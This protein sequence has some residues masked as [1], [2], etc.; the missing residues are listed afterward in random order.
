MRSAISRSGWQ[1]YR[2]GTRASSGT[3]K[4]GHNQSAVVPNVSVQCR[5]PARKK[6]AVDASFNSSVFTVPMIVFTTETVPPAPTPSRSEYAIAGCCWRPRC[7]AELTRLIWAAHESPQNAVIDLDL[8][9][10]QCAR[11]T[12][13]AFRVNQALLMPNDNPERACSAAG[14]LS[15]TPRRSKSES[16]LRRS[17]AHSMLLR[18]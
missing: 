2:R 8:I 11:S 4:S 12:T 1:R 9:A 13:R 18:R 10:F 3:T 16:A 5:L 17:G 15:R 14:E 7:C 6:N